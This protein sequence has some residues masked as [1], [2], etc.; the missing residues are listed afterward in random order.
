MLSH[1]SLEVM[2]LPTTDTI[3]YKRCC[4]DTG[5]GI[6]AADTHAYRLSIGIGRFISTHISDTYLSEHT[7]TPET[8]GGTLILINLVVM[9]RHLN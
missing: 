1:H 3:T 7:V 2:A 6:S 4:T 5:I 8:F 9:L